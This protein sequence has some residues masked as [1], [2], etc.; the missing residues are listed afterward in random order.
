MKVQ[1]KQVDE[2]IWNEEIKE[3]LPSKIFDA[4]VHTLK[5]DF[6]SNCVPEGLRIY[7][8]CSVPAVQKKLSFLFQTRQLQ[9]LFTG[10][11]STDALIEK[12]NMYLINCSKKYQFNFLVIVTPQ[13]TPSYLEKIV[14]DKNCIGFKPYKCF[15]S[16]SDPEDAKITDY[17]PEHQIEIANEYGLLITLHLSKRKGIS[18]PENIDDLLY[19]SEKY[20]CVSWNLAHCG[21]SYFPENIEKSMRNMIR[22]KGRN[23]FFDTSAVADRCVFEI[24]FSEFG[25]D[26][27]IYG[28]DAPICF[29]RGKCVRFGYDWA[30]ITKETHSITASFPVEP[31]LL[32]YEQLWAMC[33]AIKKLKFSKKQANEIFFENAEKVIKKVKSSKRKHL[34]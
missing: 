31:A 17:L 2:R 22:L 34:C 12:Q 24:L 6:F 28:S 25:A 26:Y 30:F 9:F 27:I 19:L 10:W 21:R 33:H 16:K 1:I 4:H 13:F 8:E 7:G 18:D 3:I 5:K 32:L 11:P 15:S 20:P 23:V 14:K 29:H